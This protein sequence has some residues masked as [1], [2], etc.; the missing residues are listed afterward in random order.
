MPTCFT[1][2]QRAGTLVANRILLDFTQILFAHSH[3]TH[4]QPES[5]A[6]TPDSGGQKFHGFVF[7]ACVAYFALL[8]TASI[9]CP[10]ACAGFLNL[11]NSRHDM[12]VVW[13]WA[14]NSS[15][16]CL[17]TCPG[18]ASVAVL[19]MQMSN[20]LIFRCHVNESK[21]K[22]IIK[23]PSPRLP[24]SFPFPYYLANQQAEMCH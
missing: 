16:I 23:L 14:K 1:M 4:P 19:F 11:P 10:L 20:I 24:K 13:G 6:R 8:R 9:P 21:R 22:Y 15:L 5:V 17:S 18:S 12:C 3:W 7:T 2:P